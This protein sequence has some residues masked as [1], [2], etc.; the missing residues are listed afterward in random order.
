[1]NHLNLNLID[2]QYYITRPHTFMWNLEITK[3]E[4]NLNI[5]NFINATII[6]NLRLPNHS[7]LLRSFYKY[8][9]I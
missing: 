2:W 4:I 8:L 3:I 6:F 7:L 9:I 5:Y 1:M